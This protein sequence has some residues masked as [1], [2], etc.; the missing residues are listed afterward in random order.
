MQL[1]DYQFDAVDA[2]L[3]YFMEGGTG[4]P[5]VAMPTGTGKSVVIAS[6]VKKI[7]QLYSKQ[8]VMMLTH[9]K[10][11]IEQNFEKFMAVWPTAPAGIYSAGLGRKEHAFPITFAGI[12]SVRNKAD[13]F[14]HIDLILID[15]CH[16]VSTKEST[17]YRKF[18]NDLMAYNP[19]LKVIGYTATHYRVGQGLLTEA[20]G[21]F[22]DICIDM[23]EMESFNWFFDNGYLCRLIPRPMQTQLDVSNVHLQHGEYNSHELQ[24]AVD[25]E[26][27]TRAALI[28]AVAFGEDRDHW[29]VFASGVDHAIHITDMLNELGVSARCV[30]SKM[31][32]AERDE[33]IRD[34]RAGKY[35]AIVNNGILTTGFDYPLID[36]IL[37]LRPTRSPGLWVQML[38]RGIRPVFAEGF[39]LSTVEGRLAAIQQSCKPNCLVLDFARNTEV[40]GPINDPILPKA[41]GKGGNGEAPVRICDACGSYC[42]ASL[43][44]CPTCGHLFPRDVKFGIKPGTTEL[45]KKEDLPEVLRFDVDRMTYSLHTKQGRPDSLKVSYYSGIRRFEEWICFEHEGYAK[46]KAHRWWRDRSKQDVPETSLAALERVNE[47]EPAHAIRVWVN[48]K[49]PE[50]MSYEFLP[51]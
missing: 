33:N 43:L 25:K 21:L 1:R 31:T 18:I 7:F 3:N 37:V 30:H 50:I 23:T 15:E 29:L 40:I 49:Y 24:L 2:P 6:F 51:F 27:I 17:M 4:H 22:T 44:N 47:L 42:H 19:A 26:S 20:E 39:D 14:G 46:H 13:L 38:G 16:L 41:K 28:E 8:R 36:M 48:K 12:A 35:R 9:V 32:D 11:L 34:Y 5:I 45:I 10:E